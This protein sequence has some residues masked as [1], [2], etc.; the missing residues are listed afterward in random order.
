MSRIAA[1]LARLERSARSGDE[2]VVLLGVSTT[3]EAL[4]EM[5]RRV[6]DARTR[7]P[8]VRDPDATDQ[9][10]AWGGTSRSGGS[11]LMGTLPSS[12]GGNIPVSDRDEGPPAAQGSVS[13]GGFLAAE[14]A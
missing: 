3:R 12:G 5:L 1:R 10:E 9:P 8:V 11:K 13:N 2:R 4:R 7:I 6:V 14:V